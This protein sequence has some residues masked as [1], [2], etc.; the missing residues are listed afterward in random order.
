MRSVLIAPDSFKGTMGAAEAAAAI[1]DGWAS[2]RPDDRVRCLALADGGEGTIHAVHASVLGSVLRS[3]G[4]VTGPDGRSIDGFWLSLPGGIALIELAVSSGLPLMAELDPFGATTRGMG[5][6]IRAAVRSG[7]PRLIIALGG[8]A[9]TDGGA[10]ALTALGVV[11]SAAGAPVPDGARGLTVMDAVDFRRMMPPPAGGVTLLTDVD[12][13]LLGPRGAAAAFARQKGAIAADIPLLDEALR[14]YASVLGGN[15]DAAG[16]GAAGGTAF[17]FATTWGAA[18]TTGFDAIA[19]LTGFDA[20]LDDANIVITGEGRF[21]EQSSRGKVVG[22]VLARAAARGTQAM[23]VAGS[24]SSSSGVAE[25][26]L[27]DLAG[28]TSAALADPT[29]WARAAGASLAAGLP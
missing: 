15:P 22:G 27:V 26:S 21:D 13:P 2:V 14:R 28:S 9:S 1:A 12:A 3:A 20:A 18:I 11:F 24:F 25:A 17:G 10:G 16:C 19:N 4:G 29:R 6:V 5:E 8:S 7:A 23:I